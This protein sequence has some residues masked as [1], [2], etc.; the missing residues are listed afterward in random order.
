MSLLRHLFLPHHTNNQRARILHPTGIGILV[1]VFALFQ[2]ILT[3]VTRYQ[4]EILGYASQISPSEIVRLTN[5]QR[6]SQGLPALKV[7]AQL[8][9]AAAQKASDMFAKNYWAHIS[10]T[11]TQP[12]YFITTSGYTYRYAGENLARDFADPNS[13]VTAWMN[14]PTHRENIISNRYSDIGVAVIDGNLDGRDTTLV[15]QMFGTRLSVGTTAKVS[16]LSAQAAML[17]PTTIPIPTAAVPTTSSF[18][19]AKAGPVVPVSV[20]PF[21]I[22]RLVSLFILGILALVLFADVIIVNQKKLYRW[23]SKSLAHFIFIGMLIIAAT[24]IIRGQ[25]L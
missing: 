16:G 3:Q 9:A 25:I 22:T 4:P 11:G 12:W 19:L 6:A 21:N 20:N 5:I 7:D 13:V 18:V 10:P 14:S 24:T 8:S 15:V 1:G 17:V 2:V 23:T